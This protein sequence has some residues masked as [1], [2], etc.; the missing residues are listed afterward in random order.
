[1][2]VNIRKIKV[3]LTQCRVEPQLGHWAG[4][5]G[6]AWAEVCARKMWPTHSRRRQPPAWDISEA[7]CTPQTDCLPRGEACVV[8]RDH[9]S[10][11]PKMKLYVIY[12]TKRYTVPCKYNIWATKPN[13]NYLQNV[14]C[15]NLSWLECIIAPQSYVF[16]LN[17]RVKLSLWR[18]TLSRLWAKKPLNY[19]QLWRICQAPSPWVWGCIR[20]AMRFITILAF[21]HT[22]D[23]L[24]IERL[25]Q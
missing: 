2:R 1:M 5:K 16:T 19:W 3:A 10:P 17:R 18:N 14:E 15:W 6:T 13:A 20:K 23:S 22:I 9:I 24:I 12:T 4:I 8:A 11:T 21:R 25:S 7:H